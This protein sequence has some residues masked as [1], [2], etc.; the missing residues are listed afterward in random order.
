MMPQERDKYPRTSND[1]V[2]W[3][4][5]K[6]AEQRK[7]RFKMVSELKPV[8]RGKVCGVVHHDGRKESVCQF[9]TKEVKGYYHTNIHKSINAREAK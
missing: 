4:Y 6:G 2:G 8:R 1:V 3:F 5:A 9:W 7:K